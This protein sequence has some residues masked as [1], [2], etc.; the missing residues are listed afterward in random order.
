MN[1]QE[2]FEL[3]NVSPPKEAFDVELDLYEIGEYR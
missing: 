1:E 2:D 3:E